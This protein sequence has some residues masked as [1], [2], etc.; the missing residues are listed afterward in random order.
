VRR[1]SRRGA[2]SPRSSPPFRDGPSSPSFLFDSSKGVGYKAPSSGGAGAGG[3]LAGRKRPGARKKRLTAREGVGI[4][5][6]RL[7][8]TERDTRGEDAGESRRVDL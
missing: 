6:V 8:G 1:S 2:R 5:L 4:F 7:A 3:G